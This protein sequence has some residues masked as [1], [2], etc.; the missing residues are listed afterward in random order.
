MERLPFYIQSSLINCVNN[1]N[2]FSSCYEITLLKQDIN[3][4]TNKSYSHLKD[5]IQYL[6]KNCEREDKFEVCYHFL[7]IIDYIDTLTTKKK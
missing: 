2:T 6:I 5:Y 7:K 3:R 4:L 1:V